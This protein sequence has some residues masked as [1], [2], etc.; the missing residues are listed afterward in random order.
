[1]GGQLT[2]L[3]RHPLGAGS[4]E[5]LRLV[6]CGLP[7]EAEHGR[8][9]DHADTFA[10]GIGGAEGVLHLRSG[11]EDDEFKVALLLLSD[12]CSLKG[13]LPTGGHLLILGWTNMWGRIQ[14]AERK[15][16]EKMLKYNNTITLCISRGEI[17]S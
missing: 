17:V 6:F 3:H 5:Q 13:S 9:G 4:G 12:V 7:V 10:Q 11:G 1:M 15:T 2:H 14:Q 8:D 16:S